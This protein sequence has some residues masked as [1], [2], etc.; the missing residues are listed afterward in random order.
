MKIFF[1]S[2][3]VF[4][5]ATLS[6]FSQPALDW[7]QHY[8]GPSNQGDEAVSVARDANG[9]SFVTGSSTG[10][11]GTLDI[12]TIK[13]S[14]TGQQ[15][16]LQ[17]YNGTANDNDQ[18]YKLILDNSGNV[19]VTGYSKGVSSGNDIITI[20]YSNNGVQQW[21]ST[22]DGAFSGYDEGASLAVDGS[23]N[24]Y[25]TGFETTS[26]NF[27]NDCVTIKYNSAGAQQWAQ[28]YD[29]TGS[30]NDMGKDILVDAGGN[31]FVV[32]QSDT[33]YNSNPNSDIVLLNYNTSGAL[34]WRRV[35]ASPTFSYDIPRKMCFDRN[36]NIIIVGY[37]GLAGEGDNFYTIKYSVAGVFQ[38]FMSYNY[39]TNTYEQPWDVVTDS[40]NNVIVTG[41]GIT[42]TST[43]T[44]DYVTVK[45]NSAGV[46]QWASRYNGPGNNHDWA[47]GI[48]VD[49]SLCI[50]VTGSSKGSG[51]QF[52][53]ATVKYDPA[54]NQVY[55]LRYNNSPV[56]GDDAGNDIVISNGEIFVAGRSASSANGDD[57][58]LLKY[59]YASVGIND[60]HPTDIS[61]R[62]F[63][64]PG[65]DFI[66]VV[67]PQNSSSQ[68]SVT[69]AIIINSLGQTVQTIHPENQN[70]FSNQNDF[71]LNLNGFEKGIYFISLLS[72]GQIIGTEKFV[73]N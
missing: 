73:V 56:N 17:S 31:I 24:V 33:M 34:Q 71:Y 49:D 32:A 40:L 51:T 29:G 11:S 61:F 7:A 63:P 43:S 45:Y 64:D 6:C 57:Y 26:N 12:V 14:P 54:G 2:V 10:A 4:C 38:W 68:N 18:G 69:T 20:K 60:P 19:Y 9:N 30:A 70:S 58:V 44:N 5:S 62:V 8:N 55:V 53:A 41:Q 1:L 50:Y 46:F 16:W 47:Y 72:G 37:G 15:L 35:Y 42:S 21:A 66:H 65:H 59:D 36:N 13:Y 25:V 23:G 39:G 22:Y 28:T 67:Y 27:Y 52:D 3:I 48:A